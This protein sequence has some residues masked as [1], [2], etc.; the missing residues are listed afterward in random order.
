MHLVWRKKP[1]Y[2]NDLIPL[3]GECAS[4]ISVE[5]MC[6]SSACV[7]M[8]VHVCTREL[9][10]VCASSHE[11]VWLELLTA[12]LHTKAVDEDVAQSLSVWE[13]IVRR[14]DTLPHKCSHT[15]TL[16]QW[17]ISTMDSGWRVSVQL[18]LQWPVSQ[19]AEQWDCWVVWGQRAFSVTG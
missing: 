2:H 3:P 10:C 6:M 4:I 8:C 7:C 13:C 18:E 5:Y 1:G 11:S 9:K 15:H 17:H 19:L 14:H 12:W 16:L